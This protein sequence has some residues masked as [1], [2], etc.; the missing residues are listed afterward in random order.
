M[1]NKVY[2]EAEE[3]LGFYFL[4]YFHYT[5]YRFRKS[6]TDYDVKKLNLK[7]YALL[8]RILKKF[9]LDGNRHKRENVYESMH[10]EANQVG[11][12]LGDVMRECGMS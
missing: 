10:Q 5:K 8:A 1:K 6:Y 7:A 9:F 11:I 3:L 12:Y 4:S 2:F